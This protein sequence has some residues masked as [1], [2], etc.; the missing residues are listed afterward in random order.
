MEGLAQRIVRG[1]VPEN[2]K[3][4]RLYALDM[5][6][7]VAGAKYRGEFEER[8]KSVLHEVHQAH[9]GVILFIDEIHLVLGAGSAGGGGDSPMDA[10]NLLKPMLARGQL[11]CIGATTLDEYKRHVEKDGAFE[12]RFQPVMVGEPT[13]EETISIL[14]GLKDAYQAHHGVRIMDGALVVA[15]QLAQRYITQRRLPDKAIDL[16]DEACA[17]TRVQLDSQ[18]EIMDQLERRRLQLEIEATALE[19]ECGSGVVVESESKSGSKSKSPGWSSS[20][21]TTLADAGSVQRLARV[22]EEMARIGEELRPLRARYERERGRLEE[23][24]QLQRKLEELRA[25]V[26]DGE[27]RRDLALVADLRYYAIPEVERRIHEI[28]QVEEQEQQEQQEAA[29]KKR[30]HLD[31]SDTL[32]TP[33]DSEEEEKLLS[34]TVGPEQIMDVVHRWTGI[35]VTRL[36]QGQ[37]DRLLHLSDAL[38]RRVIGQEEAVDAVADAVLRSRAGLSREHQP[39]GSFLFLGPTGVG[40]SCR[41]G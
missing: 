17:S 36:N 12:R 3:G 26:T 25:K 40:R 7:L 9:G 32:D 14:R 31:A 16:V 37:A 41:V 2:L 22:H 24:R 1:D 34:E 23:S 18:P 39:Y 15:A 5:G 30:K 4:R 21:P 20:K 19:K 28:Q 6:S 35:P 11:R 27:R 13:V 10:A 38:H 29:A 33:A 8:L